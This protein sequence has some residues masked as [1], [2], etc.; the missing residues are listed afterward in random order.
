MEQQNCPNNECFFSIALYYFSPSTNY[1]IIKLCTPV[2][3]PFIVY[4]TFNDCIDWIEK[5]NWCEQIMI[6]LS[7]RNIHSWKSTYDI[8]VS[9][10]ILQCEQIDLCTW[11]WMQTPQVSLSISHSLLHIQQHNYNLLAGLCHYSFY[12][13]LWSVPW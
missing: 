12:S 8:I 13:S 1:P 7:L 11:T 5:K 2:T 4:S 9:F 3:S 10:F 6:V